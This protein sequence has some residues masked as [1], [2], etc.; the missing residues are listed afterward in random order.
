[1]LGV[2]GFYDYWRLLNLILGV[3][4][5]VWLMG[6]L[7]RQYAQWNAKTRDLWYSRL[8]W[9]VVTV[10]LSYEGIKTNAGSTYA[11]SLI[12]AAVLITFKG[13][14]KRGSWGYIAP[15]RKHERKKRWGRSTNGTTQ[16]DS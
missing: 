10:F 2:D 11:L 7:H 12:T 3:L 9:A 16:S 6:G 13:L 14:A 5:F 15:P 1:M 4:S 8:M